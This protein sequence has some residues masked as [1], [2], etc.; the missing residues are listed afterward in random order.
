MNSN[1]LKFNVTMAT[2]CK[3]DSNNKIIE[4]K[5][6]DI[7]MPRVLVTKINEHGKEEQYGFFLDSE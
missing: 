6:Y 5:E 4:R 2:A 3:I 7:L 1:R